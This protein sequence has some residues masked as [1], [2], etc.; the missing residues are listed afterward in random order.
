MSDSDDTPTPPDEV[1]QVDEAAPPGEVPQADEVTSP[2]V[3]SRRAL[4]VAS[5]VVGVVAVLGL[6]G[7]VVGFWTLRTA[8]DSGRFE[9]RV[10]ELL[11]DEEISNALGVRVVNEVTATLDVRAAV[12]DVAPDELEPMLDVLLAGVRSRVE[13]RAGQLI[14]SDL[15]AES[16]GESVERA[17]GVAIQVIEG[18]SVVDG[19]DVSD[20]EVRVN[21]LPLTA[22]VIGALQE[23]GLFRDVDVPELERGGDPDEQREQLSEALGRDL[24]DDFGEPVMF[25]SDSLEQVGDTVELARDTLVFAKRTFWLLF[26][27]GT[28]FA[29][30]SIWLARRRWRAACYIV[31]GLFA[32]TLVVRLFSAETRERI[33]DIVES[34]GAQAAVVQIATGLENSLNR[35]LIWFSLLT[36]LALLV[37]MWVVFGMSQVSRDDDA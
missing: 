18:D 11:R 1:Q 30:G 33:P 31:A 32:G 34:A 23:V 4:S 17:H 22:R 6:I 8:S 19:V 29:A 27:A 12:H 36:L 7:G 14:R 24:P 28:A 35:T 10:E 16:I 3:S 15:V 26:L 13:S 9:N 2:A 21:L 20:G 5:A 37:T 25:R